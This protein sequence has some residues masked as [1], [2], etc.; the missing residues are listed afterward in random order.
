VV[1]L[2]ELITPA[3]RKKRDFASAR[4]CQERVLKEHTACLESNRGQDP[5]ANLPEGSLPAPE[6]A[7]CTEAG[8]TV[9]M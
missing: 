4:T 1:N 5:R 9:L 7:S 8:W 3:E 6:A 2:Q